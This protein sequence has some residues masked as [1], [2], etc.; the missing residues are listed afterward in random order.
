MQNDF[1]YISDGV[2]DLLEN[3]N[4]SEKGIEE[5]LSDCELSDN[6]QILVPPGIVLFF[7]L[8]I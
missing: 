3:E 4:D 5:S 1:N 2:N 8:S 6:V 7:F